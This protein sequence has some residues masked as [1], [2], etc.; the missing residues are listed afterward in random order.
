MSESVNLYAID[1]WNNEPV[2]V[3]AAA[4]KTTNY[5]CIDETEGGS[6]PFS[7]RMKRRAVYFADDEGDVHYSAQ[8]AIQAYLE[9]RR[10]ACKRIESNLA[11]AEQM[12]AKIEDGHG[13][14][15]AIT[16]PTDL[17]S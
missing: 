9:K 3:K 2:L 17:K 7:I 6:W 16:N 8:D 12:L 14:H 15:P 5:F 11:K 1:D 10:E 13:Q 4:R